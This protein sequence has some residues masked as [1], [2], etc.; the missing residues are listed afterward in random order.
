LMDLDGRKLAILKALIEDYIET[1]EPVGSRTIAKKCDIGLS[2]ATIRNEMSDLEEMGYLAQPHTSAGRI[3]SNLAYRLYVD[4]LIENIRATSME[5]EFIKQKME[6]HLSE[7]NRFLDFSAKAISDSTG[8]TA[9]TGAPRIASG[10]IS[11]FEIVK[12]SEHYL[13]FIL[14][15][16]TGMIKKRQ[17]RILTPI[18]ENSILYLKKILNEELAGC[19]LDM[20]TSEKVERL[21]RKFNDNF[22]LLGIIL[23]FITQTMEAAGGSEYYFS[24]KSETLKAPEFSSMDKVLGFLD[25]VED[26]EQITSLMNTAAS[27]NKNGITVVIGDESPILK[28]KDLSMVVST[29]KAYGGKN[30]AIAVI[31]PKRMNYGKVI[32]TLE[33]MSKLMSEFLENTEEG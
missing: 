3:P 6:S 1:A 5:M 8:L 26:K 32:T 24:G 31:G 17:V 25:L 19:T 9:I 13:M 29:Y 7:L 22:E 33:A 11:H 10:A 12:A 16:N 20:I 14:V 15:T 21:K 2:S 23:E 30:G 18:D 4:S 27:E 28:N